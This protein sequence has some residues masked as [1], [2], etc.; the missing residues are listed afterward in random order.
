M[1]GLDYLKLLLCSAPLALTLNAC[2]GGGGGDDDDPSPSD[3]SNRA[4]VAENVSVQSDLSSPYINIKLIANDPDN[5]TISFVLDASST[6]QGYD[7][8]FIDPNTGHLYVTLSSG[9]SDSIVL[10]YKATDGSLYSEVAEVT[11]T[12]GELQNGG[13]GANDIPA[14]EYG[15][16]E[17]AFFDGNRFGSPLGDEPTMPSSIDLSGSFPTPGNQ[18]AQN[19]CVGW[20]SGY[21]LKSYHEKIEEQWEFSQ[22]TTFSPAW[23]YNQINGGQDGGAFLHDAL[24]LIVDRGAATWS[25]MPYD[26]NDYL[27]QP[28][29]EAVDQASNFKAVSY[30]AISSAQQMKA[31]LANRNPVLAGI[32]VYENLPLLNGPD[33]VYNTTTGEDKGGHAVTL[34][35]Y[36]DNKY[37][38]AFKVINSWGNTWGDNGFFW[39][40]YNMISTVMNQA[41]VLTDG[42]N[43][44]NPNDDVD[45]VPVTPTPTDGDLPNLEVGNW[46]LSY[47]TNAGGEGS[48]TW[49]VTNAGTGTAP[50]GV[51]VNLILSTDQH[52]DTSDWLIVYEEIP[53]ELA[54]G[55]TAVRDASDP[56]TFNL[57]ENLPA[58]EYYIA[59]W[60]DSFQEVEESDEQDNQSFGNKQLTI[61]TQSLPDIAIDWWWAEWDD[62]GNGLLEYTVY[63]DGTA[64]TSRTDWDINLVLSQTEDVSQGVFYLFYENANF[65]M[66]PGMSI[67]RSGDSAA[68]FN[69]FQSQQGNSIPS[70]TYYM[71]LW[72]DDQEEESES[73]EINNLS[74]GNGLVSVGSSYRPTQDGSP[75]KTVDTVN[76]MRA[77]AYDGMGEE[78]SRMFNGKRIPDNDVLM[79]KVT[80]SDQPDGT[81]KIAFADDD[82][83]AKAQQTAP[84]AGEKRYNK[85]IRSA[86][87][88]IFPKSN[89]IEM[90]LA[91]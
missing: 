51:D 61:N 5:D 7:Q 74:V 88:A 29:Q 47:E 77:Y 67:Y 31:A 60:V 90:P 19:S 75:E 15:R 37:G 83:P 52:M 12:I 72:V 46:E 34:V 33:S 2:G 64:P 56:R 49:E 17:L 36:D 80:I 18:G 27:G 13:L 32:R 68:S 82:H 55:D 53:S 89:R 69:L 9:A 10:P 3:N 21:A 91:Q 20:A 24:Q 43:T 66:E 79:R 35:G 38:G 30:N 39:L 14:E 57:P 22:A 6:G 78:V 70:G 71:S 63:N 28:S 8:A 58:G 62:Y 50:A 45:D 65:I 48:W 85:L 26:D 86:D 23:I 87:Q 25:T 59:V 76:Q 1:N 11:I 40:P 42:T 81:R 16:L 41:L 54:P 4:P 44:N 84:L 73:N